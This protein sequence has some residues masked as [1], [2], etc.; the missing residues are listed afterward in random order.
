MNTERPGLIDQAGLTLQI[1]NKYVAGPWP[2]HFPDW[3]N[4]IML[5]LMRTNPVPFLMALPGGD[6]QGQHPLHPPQ[7]GSIQELGM[8]QPRS[9]LRSHGSNPVAGWA[10]GN[11]PQPF[12][13][14]S[15]IFILASLCKLLAFATET[16]SKT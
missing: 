4:D 10:P 15:S 13:P 2:R 9:N 12:L 6:G 7:K 5:L 8:Q 11:C 14:H 1:L 16:Y 3:L